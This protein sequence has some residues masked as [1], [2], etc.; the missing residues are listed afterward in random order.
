MNFFMLPKLYC[1]KVIKKV[2]KGRVISLVSQ[3]L[4]VTKD[5]TRQD[6]LFLFID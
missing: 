3:R 6:R 2:T 4:D 5:N 1:F